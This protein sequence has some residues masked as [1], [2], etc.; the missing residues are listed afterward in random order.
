MSQFIFESYTADI[1]SGILSFSYILENQ[2]E[3]LRFHESLLLPAKDMQPIPE[4]VLHQL[5]QA[6]HIVLGLSY[7]K[8]YCPKK[9]IINNFTLSQEQAD[10]WNMVY[11]K[12]LGEFF[13]RNKID[14]RGLIQFPYDKDHVQTTSSYQ[15]DQKTYLVGIGGGKDSIVSAELLKKH[16]VPFEGFIIETQKSYPIIDSIIEKIGV[17]SVRVKR[18]IDPQLFRVNARTDV[19]NG[20]V[21][22]SSIYAWIGILISVLYGYRGLIVSNERSANI[23]NVSYLGSTINHQWSK[24][25]EFER[26]LRKYIAAYI[27]EDIE[28]LSL[29]RPFSEYSIVQLFA[30]YL[31]YFSVFS[32]CNRNFSI[33]NS[34]QSLW[35]GD[36]PK[37]AFVFA[38]LAAFVPQ[39]QLLGIFGQNLF[40]KPSLAVTYEELLGVKGFKPFECV[41]TPAEIRL[42]MYKVHQKGEYADT[43]MMKRFEKDVLPKLNPQQLEDEVTSIDNSVLPEHFQHII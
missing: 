35:C 25:Y 5:L 30:E 15:S 38:L 8:T 7:W 27:S 10:Y 43:L 28:Y 21:P 29:L 23:G 6:V 9:L 32:S 11:T 42:A 36:C 1:S 2:G 12:G 13:Y 34:A 41:G 16:A 26:M 18:V 14:Y 20:H 31:Q 22:I 37:C 19:F 3:E 24:S 4:P 40:D 33:Q 39:R 17:E